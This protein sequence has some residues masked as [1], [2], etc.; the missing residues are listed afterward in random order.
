[1][2]ETRAALIIASYRYKDA[3]LRG[4][5]APAQDAEALARV[6]ADPAIGDFEVQTL[7]D[8]PSHRVSRAIEAFFADRKRDDLLL[9]YFSGHGIKDEEGRLYLS[10]ADTQRKLLR[11]TAIPATF[12]NDV[13]RYSRSRRQVLLLDCCYSGAF[14]RGMVAKTDGR[15]G[16]IECFGGR[17]RVVLTASDAM[18][19]AFEGDKVRGKGVRSVF[20]Q[21]LVHGL[22]TGKADL[23]G[24]GR[25]SFDELYD[26]VY[27]RV[28]DQTP[29]QTP[30][31]WALGVQGEIIIARNPT[32]TV[33]AV[34]LP[35]KPP[36]P[37]ESPYIRGHEDIA[38]R[39]G[40]LRWG[41]KSISLRTAFLAG[42]GLL[43]AMGVGVWVVSTSL[44]HP[45]APTLG[46]TCQPSATPVRMGVAQL[47]NCPNGFQTLLIAP[48]MNKAETIPLDQAFAASTQARA[49]PDYDIIVWGSCD[50]Q[51]NEAVTLNYELTTTRK[52]D[53]IYEPPN[54]RM[55]GNLTNAVDVGLALA[56]YQHGDYTDAADRF[57]EMPATR[58]SP[59]L[60]LLWANSLLFA[61]R[62][63]E[64]IRAYRETALALNPA[65]SAAYT[66]LGVARFNR[67]L[68]TLEGYPTHGLDDF[69]QA[70]RLA[71]DQGEAGL[72]LLA[73]INRSDSHRW[74]ESHRK[75]L[76]DCEAALACD[77]QSALPYVCRVLY[78]FSF[79]AGSEG[80]PFDEI[81]RDLDQAEQS[82]DVPA[83]LHFLRASWH[84]EQNNKQEAIAAY[85]RFLELMEARACIQTDVYY[86]EDAVY[87]IGELT[88]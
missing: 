21:A 34:G 84:R 70:I 7:L 77:A 66:N 49:Q 12:V 9:L 47:P 63:D 28:S 72:A 78:S 24:D 25:I 5:I 88:R 32:P 31:K 2:V 38:R 62:Y 86:V 87:F 26:Y 36:Q 4:L 27:D 16:T 33:E 23:N 53:E 45:K 3:D 73:Y 58:T 19:Y 41:R 81:K 56:S 10:T 37:I 46:P 75:A 44:R 61:G 65:W 54:L 82:G 11:A 8:E 79:G 55:T 67:D 43:V 71:N 29:Q 13:M 57:N 85:E 52:P 80:I 42:L 30:G 59:E 83:K 18:Q 50:E 60:A 76:S 39:P 15:I 74:S 17:G 22:E 64:A 68:L 14:A 20:T 6:L 35:P 48:W 69:D 1:M 51:E 40:R